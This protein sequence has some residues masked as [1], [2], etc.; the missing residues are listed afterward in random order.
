[1]G[2]IPLEYQLVI[3]ELVEFWQTHYEP[4]NLMEHAHSTFRQGCDSLTFFFLTVRDDLRTD[5]RSKYT[6]SSALEFRQFLE[7][8]YRRLYQ[9][10]AER[11][12]EAQA[13]AEAER[14][15]QMKAENERQAQI[16]AEKER[17]AQMKPENEKRARADFDAL[18]KLMAKATDRKEIMELARKREDLAPYIGILHPYE[19]VCWKCH[20]RVSSTIHL[21]CLKCRWLVC[22]ICGSCKCNKPVSDPFLPDFPDE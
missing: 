6:A 22:S 4:R 12:A 7:V 11:Q 21:R 9:L 19:N 13:K 1:M 16:R 17:L 5:K 14:L 15:A 10:C 3:D 18:G 8:E 20:H 2:N